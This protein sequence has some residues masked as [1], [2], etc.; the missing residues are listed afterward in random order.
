HGGLAHAAG[1]AEEIGVGD[2]VL[3][4]GVAQRLRDGLLPDDV[5][6]AAGAVTSCQDGVGH[7]RGFGF[8]VPGFWLTWSRVRGENWKPEPETSNPPRGGGERRPGHRRH[9]A[10]DA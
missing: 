3:L 1:A 4:D 10:D 9:R 5:G 7:Q 8:L 2:A 6:E